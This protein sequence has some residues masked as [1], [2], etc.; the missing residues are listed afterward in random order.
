MPPTSVPRFL[1][2]MLAAS[3]AFALVNLAARYFGYL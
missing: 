2:W 1:L 3:I